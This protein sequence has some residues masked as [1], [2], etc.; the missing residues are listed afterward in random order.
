LNKIKSILISSVRPEPTSAGQIILYRHLVNKP[1]I[2]LEVY[3]AELKRFSPSM[4]LRRVLGRI[5][6]CGGVFDI[7]VN[8]LWV[9]WEGRWIDRD[10]HKSINPDFTTIVMTVAQGEGFHAAQ[11]FAKRHNLPLVVFFH[12]WWPDMAAV[13]RIFRRILEKHFILLAKECSLG[14]CV[15]EGMKV[16]LGNGL[17]LKVFPP[18]PAKQDPAGIAQQKKSSTPSQF[19]I[20]YA[21][22]L[23]DYGTKLGMALEESLKHPEIQLQ[24]R[25]TNPKWT[26]EFKQKMR[27]IGCWLEFAPRAVLDEWMASADAFLIPMVFDPEMRRRMET[28]FPSKLI[29]MAQ[30]GRPLVIW[31]PE[32]CSAVQWARQENRALCVTDPDPKVLLMALEKL[33]S[34][35]EA[36][37]R[38]S[39]AAREAAETEFS[40][41]RIQAQFMEALR[42]SLG[43]TI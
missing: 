29:E 10:L 24:V 42:G 16:A 31:G 26:N 2:E 5:A 15:C 3:G 20:L 22:N 32:Y 19:R 43:T 14:L 13:P 40:H 12:D 7:A 33:A 4:V 39:N 9:L 34:N 17:N 18:I 37:H 41:D 11:R 8:C 35:Q 1:G 27:S 23:R 30:F 38:L 6:K 25:G 36:L 28:S 21:G